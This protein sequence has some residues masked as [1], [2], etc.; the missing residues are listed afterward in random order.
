VE[1]V[2]RVSCIYITSKDQE[3]SQLTPKLPLALTTH[4]F[5]LLA[6]NTKRVTRTYNLEEEE[7]GEGTLGRG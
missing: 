6:S 5:P 7:G 3:L 4:I 2:Q 1:L